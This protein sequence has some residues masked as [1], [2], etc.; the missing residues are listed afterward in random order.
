MYG[1]D[2]DSSGGDHSRVSPMLFNVNVYQVADKY[3]VLKLKQ[4][5]KEKFEK[6]I[7]ACWGMDDFPLTITEA[8][9]STPKTDRGLR[10]P[11]IRTALKHIEHLQKTEDFVQVLEET[12]FSADIF[13]YSISQSTN[14]SLTKY[15]CWNCD[16]QW[17]LE[18][19]VSL[20]YCPTCGYSKSNWIPNI[21]K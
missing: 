9:S 20:V 13:Q 12:G 7:E 14:P 17:Q 18:N 11:L 6:I 2:Y 15:R 1:F 4:R 3:G 10:D 21:V 8:Y 16:N 5:A 19:S